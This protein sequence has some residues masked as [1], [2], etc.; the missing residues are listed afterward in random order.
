MSSIIDISS[1]TIVVSGVISMIALLVKSRRETRSVV[2]D[3]IRLFFEREDA[4]RL[5]EDAVDH[6]ELAKKVDRLILL[7]CTN[8]EKLKHSKLCEGE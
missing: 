1:L 4:R 8:E 7:L 6:S 3:E 2:S 5:I